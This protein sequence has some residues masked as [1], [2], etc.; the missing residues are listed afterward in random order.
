MRVAK[1]QNLAMLID[2]RFKILK[3]HFISAIYHFKR[4]VNNLAVHAFRD[5]TERVVNRWL[6]NN[7]VARLGEALQNETDSLYDTGDI[8]KPFTLDFPVMF[9]MYP[10]D[11]T[12]I[13]RVRIVC[14]PENLVFTTFL[15]RIHNK[16]RCPEIHVGY[17]KRHKVLIAETFFQVVELDAVRTPALDD[18]VKIV[19]FHLYISS[20]LTG[21]KDT[22]YI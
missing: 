16:V 22:N 3:I 4:I 12:I 20:E 7:F 21:V 19:L 5:N 11:N 2:N 6:D 9:I 1:N 18:L 8:T 10:L 17:P 14:V 13:I 15:D